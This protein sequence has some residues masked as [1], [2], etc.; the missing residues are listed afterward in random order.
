MPELT[1]VS[2][3]IDTFTLPPLILHPFSSVED[4]C[5]LVESSRASLVIQGLLPDTGQSP[6]ELDRSLIRGR[7]AEL[8]MLFYVGKDLSRWLEQ[9]TEVAKTEP[10]M[11]Q[12]VFTPESF[13]PLLVEHVPDSVRRKLETWGVVD[14]T[15]LF[16]RAIGLHMVFAEPPPVECLSNEFLRRYHHYMDQWFELR[17]A[18]S[19]G[20]R[21]EEHEFTYDLYASGEYAQMLEQTWK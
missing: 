11:A 6:E 3:S 7:H 14:F 19:R 5:V 17:M 9:C 8:R 18:Q 4:S 15:A 16:R 20:R 2:N 13:I 12:L 10:E 1:S 21:C